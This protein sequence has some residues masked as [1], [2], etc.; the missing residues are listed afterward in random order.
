MFNVEELTREYFTINNEFHCNSVRPK[1]KKTRSFQCTAHP[2]KIELCSIYLIYGR[3][4]ML[5]DCL[6]G[7][8]TSPS[9]DPFAHVSF[10]PPDRLCEFEFD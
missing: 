3:L 1:S 2:L 9:G 4:R 5:I 7:T 10:Y 6:E 8:K